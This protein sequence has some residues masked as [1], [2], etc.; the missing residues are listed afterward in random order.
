MNSTKI[1]TDTVRGTTAG[2]GTVVFGLLGIPIAA[3]CININSTVFIYRRI[4]ITNEN[5]AQAYG[6]R[7]MY[8]DDYAK[9]MG[10]AEVI[11]K[12]MYLN[13]N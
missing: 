4:H 10:N 13:F 8:T 1:K 7:V 6:F 12:Y 3:Y 2:N 9:P 5:D 11:V